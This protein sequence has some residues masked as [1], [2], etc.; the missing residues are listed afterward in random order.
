MKSF[1]IFL[2]VLALGAA[3]F[4]TR[5]SQDDF[6]RYVVQYQ[7]RDDHNVIST[8]IDKSIAERFADTCTIKDHYLWVNVEKDGKTVFTGAFAHWFS[9]AAVKD[10]LHK[11]D[12]NVDKKV[13]ELDQKI[14]TL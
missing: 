10:Q 2:L 11:A 3:A 5:P 9:H 14:K 12:Q 6:K 4:F 7:T 8:A 13:K 1:I